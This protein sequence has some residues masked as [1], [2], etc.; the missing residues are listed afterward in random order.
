MEQ[1][2][3]QRRQAS[4]RAQSV[5]KASEDG[6][7]RIGEIHDVNYQGQD[8]NIKKKDYKINTKTGLLQFKRTFKKKFKKT[9]RNN[10]PNDLTVIREEPDK[11]LDS[12]SQVSDD[13]KEIKEIIN[14]ELVKQ[15]IAVRK[16][17]I[18]AEFME[19]QTASKFTF[20]SGHVQNAKHIQELVDA[21]DNVYH[22]ELNM[23]S[24]SHVQ[25]KVLDLMMEEDYH[26]VEPD[27]EA[28]EEYENTQREAQ[29]KK[30][31]MKRK[32][33]KS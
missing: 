17:E 12:F 27:R 28:I 3:I 18:L 13:D 32:T 10:K 14:P 24:R 16:K 20:Q 21:L 8:E 6:L 33:R 22:E 5:I 15:A 2:A 4:Q 31:K 19:K 7:K 23:Y 11:E 1:E 30:K 26:D 29:K 9:G 25:G